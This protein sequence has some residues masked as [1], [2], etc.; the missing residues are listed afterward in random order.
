VTPRDLI[1]PA[2]ALLLLL[3]LLAAGA[4]GCRRRPS[5]PP[6]L[7]G[8]KAPPVKILY[9]SAPG[10]FVKLVAR[11]G[12]SVVHLSTNA[13]VRGGPADWF[14]TGT[15]AGPL[16]GGHTEQLQQSLGTGVIID[17][18]GTILTNAHVISK[19]EEVRVRL[20]DGTGGRAKLIGK[21]EKSDLALLA[22]SP[23][24]N[25]K[26]K[27]ARLGDSD[28]LQVGEWVVAL[29]DPFGR[30]A[31]ISAGV[32][33]AKERQDLPAGQEGFWG[34]L[35]TDVR[36][37]AGNSGGPLAN[38]LGEVVGIATAV[39]PET[40][41]IGFAVPINLAKKILPM[42]K[43]E[44]KVV[45]AWVGIYMGKLTD[46]QAQELGLKQAQGALVISVVPRGPA[47]R[48]GL[49]AGD[50]IISFDRKAIRD[51]SELPWLAS[52]AGIDRLVPLRV[53]R[54]G[55][56]YSFSLKSERMPE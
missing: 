49:R 54:G 43:R 51:A 7:P 53:W 45:R 16:V 30:G 25:V 12:P 13:P 19:A 8:D 44:G 37:N 14:P 55:K 28:Q 1:R 48:A 22:F 26:L 39:E 27:P 34:Y 46:E 20:Q 11:L 24:A 18:E 9:P 31:T 29:G 42:L 52:L 23:P 3:L 4:S 33:G 5:T 6:Q 41:G 21:D 40:G 32:L 36:I 17:M 2:G 35:Q 56:V 50:V 38:V 47:E 10:S 15:P